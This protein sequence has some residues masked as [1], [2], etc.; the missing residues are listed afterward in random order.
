MRP[1][2]V[3]ESVGCL[4]IGETKRMRM[5]EEELAERGIETVRAAFGGDLLA[6]VQEGLWKARGSGGVCIAAEGEYWP[7]ALA[8]AVQLCVDRIVLLAPKDLRR[9]AEDECGKQIERLRSFVRRNLFFCV[10][11]VLV[12]ERPG[13]VQMEKCVD[14]LCRGLC[15]ARIQRLKVSEQ[16]WTKCEFFPFEAAARFLHAGERMFSLAK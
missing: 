2:A 1:D 6:S 4:L 10:S 16:R 9:K 7:V 14:R 11:D 13:D 12:M 8:P 15:N 3:R 5:L